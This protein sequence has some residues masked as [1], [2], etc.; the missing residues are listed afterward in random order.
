MGEDHL[1][2]R[3]ATIC[4]VASFQNSAVEG[5]GKVKVVHQNLL[6]PFGGNVED[7]K[8]EES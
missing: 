6:L 5:E 2:S 4:W 7:S 8:N 1:S 3:G